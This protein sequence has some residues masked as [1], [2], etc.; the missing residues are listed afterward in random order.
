MNISELMAVVGCE[1]YPSRWSEFYDTVVADTEKALPDFLGEGYLDYLR[2]NFAFVSSY[3]E[4]YRKAA[5]KIRESRELTLFAALLAKASEDG[6]RISGDLKELTLPEDSFEKRMIPALVMLS[7]VP[8]NYAEMKRRKISD[9]IIESSLHTLEGG[10]P[11]YMM[12]HNGE[13][14]YA[15]FSW[16]RLAYD[17]KLYN[18]GSLQIELDFSFDAG[19]IHFT[20]SL[21][22]GITLAHGITLHRDGVALGSENYEDPDGSFDAV[23]EEDE[24]EYRGYPY[25]ESGRVD[26]EK[27]SL[28]KS[29]WKKS[30][31]PGDKVVSIHIPAGAKLDKES[32]DST[33]ASIRAFLGEHFPEYGYKAFYCHS[34]MLDPALSKIVRPTSNILGFSRRF[35][36]L[37]VKSDGTAVFRFVFMKPD[38]NFELDELPE[39]TSLERGIKSLYKNGG[40]IYETTGFFLK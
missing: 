16:F 7:A 2:E 40:A 11:S 20:N 22:E 13:I 26:A 1:A 8:K 33:F 18:I 15:F 27:I 32:L 39:S 35:I 36:P 24:T 28:K 23:T 4:H 29:E 25:N 34:W 31:E 14:G 12:R 17:A 5:S 6:E 19:A 9:D 3:E 30:L 10:I 21:G 38:M 37:T